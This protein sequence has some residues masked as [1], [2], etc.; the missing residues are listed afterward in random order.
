MIN[1]ENYEGYLF[2]YQEGELDSTTC[3]EVERFLLEHP[4]IREEMEN[5]YDPTFVVTAEPSARKHHTTIAL[6]RWAAA[7]CVVLALGYG[8]YLALP[9]QMEGTGMVAQTASSTPNSVTPLPEDT[10]LSDTVRPSTQIAKASIPTP[11]KQT[12][13]FELASVTQQALSTEMAEPK[14]C[15]EDTAQPVT[16]EVLN[17]V[18]PIVVRSTQLAEVNEIIMVDDLAKVI[19]HA[20]PSDTPPITYLT[21]KIRRGIEN[22]RLEFEEFVY[23]IFAPKSESYELAESNLE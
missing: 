7:A 9:K 4:D 5:Y 3:A 2:L 12:P 10:P 23:N 1:M 21:L 20:K 15:A 22:R 18:H 19:P 6:W 11:R 17:P 13:L 14:E 8:A 16:S